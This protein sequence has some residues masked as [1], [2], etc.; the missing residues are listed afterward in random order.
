MDEPGK[1]LAALEKR[2]DA[3]AKFVMEKHPRRAPRHKHEAGAVWKRAVRLQPMIAQLLGEARAVQDDPSHSSF[4]AN[5]IW[6]GKNGVPG[7]KGALSDMVGWHACYAL[8][9]KPTGDDEKFIKSE[10]VY[11]VCTQVVWEGL[12]ACR[13]C[14]CS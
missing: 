14:A 12:P 5:N 4:C 1:K 10:K 8:A 3:L 9:G 2:I 6:Y 7:M 11:T 13:N